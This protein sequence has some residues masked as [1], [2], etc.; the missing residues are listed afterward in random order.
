[1]IYGLI[2]YSVTQRT[3]EIDIRIALGAQPR[4]VVAPVIREGLL[5]ALAGLAIGLVGS[6]AAARALSRFLF[7]VEATDPLTFGA[8]SLLLLIVALIASYIPSRRA[9]RVDPIVALRTE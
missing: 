4:Q 6:F 7:G 1:V 9:M 5:L 2:S 8:V 3:R